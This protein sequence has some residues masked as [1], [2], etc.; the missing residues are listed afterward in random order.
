MV[1]ELVN[2]LEGVAIQGGDAQLGPLRACTLRGENYFLGS[3]YVHR[4]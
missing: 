4:A 3:G 1:G 2:V